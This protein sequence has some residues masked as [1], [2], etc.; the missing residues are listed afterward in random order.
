MGAAE[1]MPVGAVGFALIAALTWFISSRPRLY[2]LVFV[3]R[4]EWLGVARWAFREE[5]R[6]GMRLMAG[7]QFAVACVFGLVGFWLCP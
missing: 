5:Y 4:D 3:P 1:A 6:R 7:L 2:L